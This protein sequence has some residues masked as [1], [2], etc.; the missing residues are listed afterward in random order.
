M[1]GY[2]KP[3]RSLDIRGL[4]KSFVID[5]RAHPVFSG[6]DLSIERGE[7]VAI[8]GESGSGKTTLLR[9]IAGLE[10]ADGGSVAVA[11]RRVDGV[12]AERGMVFQEPRLLP[13]LTVRKNVSIG[14]ELRRLPRSSIDRMVREFLDL[15]GLGEFASAYPSQ[16][17][18]GMAQRVGIAR[19]LATNPEI[20][21]LDEPL[22]ALD[23]MTKLRMQRELERIWQE[24]KVTMIMVTHDIEEAVYLADK[25]VV[26]AGGHDSIRRVIPVAMPRPRDRSC[27]EFGEVREKLLRE[28]HLGAN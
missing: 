27:N 24:H 25:I 17:S 18:G 19:A 23:A 13:W 5:G 10:P 6:V 12:G 16:L 15:V 9:I 14:L 4:A 21:L 26:L 22:G 11:G 8:V 20:L 1:Y 3:E 7:F 28:F 2:E